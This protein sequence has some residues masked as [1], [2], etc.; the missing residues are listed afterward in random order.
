MSDDLEDLIKY[1]AKCF[2]CGDDYGIKTAKKQLESFIQKRER[3]AWEAARKTYDMGG[4]FEGWKH[5][6][7]DDWQKERP[8]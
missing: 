1:A 4:P 6:T 3:E 5:E 8:Q 2:A 7:I